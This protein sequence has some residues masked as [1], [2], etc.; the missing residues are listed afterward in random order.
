MIVA[1]FDTRPDGLTRL[2]LRFSRLGIGGMG[3]NAF[4]TPDKMPHRF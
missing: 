4:G 3:A 1:L 2:N